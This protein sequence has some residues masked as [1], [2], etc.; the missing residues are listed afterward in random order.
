MYKKVEALNNFVDMESNILNFWSE[1]E[2][3]QKN[4]VLNRD[5]KYFTFY[6]GAPTSNGKLHNTM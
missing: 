1:N 4:F 3:V 5:G 2:I 6:D